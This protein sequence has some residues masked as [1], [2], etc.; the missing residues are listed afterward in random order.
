MLLFPRKE[1]EIER[2]ERGGITVRGDPAGKNPFLVLDHRG[3]MSFHFFG[4]AHRGG[5]QGGWKSA[6]VQRGSG[7]KRKRNVSREFPCRIDLTKRRGTERIL[8][9]S[10]DPEKCP[11]SFL[12]FCGT[13]RGRR[14]DVQ[15]G[16]EKE[17]GMSCGPVVSAG[18]D[19][20]TLS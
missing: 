18:R 16:H 19:L 13:L 20:R 1:E 15:K 11:I 2:P 3:A 10:R 7:E 4:R 9:R 6:V 8:I 5:R 17:K 12:L 14:G